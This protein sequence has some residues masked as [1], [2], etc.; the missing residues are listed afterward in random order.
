VATPELDTAFRQE[1][2]RILA[3]VV[4]FTGSLELAEDAAGRGWTR[5]VERH[6]R[7]AHRIDQLLCEMNEARDGA[8][9]AC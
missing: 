3:A 5:E 2:P 8:V 6:G 4:R 9:A 7:T 1:W